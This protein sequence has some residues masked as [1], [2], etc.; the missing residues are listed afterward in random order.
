MQCTQCST[1]A[2]ETEPTNQTAQL[3]VSILC[4]IDCKQKQ[5]NV[6][7]CVFCTLHQP[8]KSVISICFEFYSFGILVHTPCTST[9]SVND[10]V[11]K[12]EMILLFRKDHSKSQ[13]YPCRSI[14]IFTWYSVLKCKKKGEKI[15]LLKSKKWFNRNFALY[16]E[17]RGRVRG[18]R[19]IVTE[20]EQERDRL[21]GR[22]KNK[23]FF[24]LP[25]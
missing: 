10:V 22:R 25:F 5:R 6:T 21:R 11:L 3:E 20:R 9:A 18:N 23:A 14:M 17:E 8:T 15:Q 7:W 1:Q 24:Q 2:T 4:S 16:T 12:Q 19:E 13:V